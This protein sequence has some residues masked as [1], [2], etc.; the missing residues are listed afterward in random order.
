MVRRF[1]ES[2]I[3][4]SLFWFIYPQEAWCGCKSCDKRAVDLR[5]KLLEQQQV[6]PE[7]QGYDVSMTDWKVADDSTD[8]PDKKKKKKKKKDD[9]KTATK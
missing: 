6:N 4:L 9:D 8:K 2:T 5:K 1:V 3:I 7:P